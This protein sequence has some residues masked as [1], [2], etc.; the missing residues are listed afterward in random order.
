MLD[1]SLAMYFDE[2]LEMQVDDSTYGGSW[3]FGSGPSLG[4]TPEAM[5][6]GSGYGREIGKGMAN[7]N[8]CSTANPP[9]YFDLWATMTGS[10]AEEF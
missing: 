6:S 2:E 9:V 8:T 3:N 4:T 5:G 10:W 7:A 1:P